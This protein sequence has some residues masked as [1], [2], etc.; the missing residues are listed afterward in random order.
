MP[1][2]R[3]GRATTIGDPAPG[4]PGFRRSLADAQ[5]AERVRHT[6]GRELPDVLTFREVQLDTLLLS[7]ARARRRFLHAELGPL[8]SD[9][10]DGAKLRA[11][12][13]AW[14]SSGSNVSA[15]AM[16]NLHDEDLDKREFLKQA[17]SKFPTGN[18]GRV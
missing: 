15:A 6:A 4:I 13:D 2:A 7:D 3:S 12:L 18:N 14:L 17:T 10:K 1:A 16:L 9:T 11:T 8:A 5:R